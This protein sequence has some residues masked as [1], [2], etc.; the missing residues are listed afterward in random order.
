MD[1][2]TKELLAEAYKNAW[3]TA[4][5]SPCTIEIVNGYFVRRVVSGGITGHPNRMS[6][7]ELIA[8]LSRLTYRVVEQGENKKIIEKRLN[9]PA[10][11]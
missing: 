7:A 6:A 2:E 11:C 5:G 4:K 10:D 9:A 1:T 3:Y 8:S